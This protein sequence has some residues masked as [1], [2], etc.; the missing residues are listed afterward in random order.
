MPRTAIQLVVDPH[1]DRANHRPDPSAL[2]SSREDASGDEPSAKCTC[3][4]SGMTG[5]MEHGAGA[6]TSPEGSSGDKVAVLSPSFAAPGV[7]PAVHEQAMTRLDEVTGLVP[8]E[9][10]TTRR[11]KAT[12]RGPRRRP[13]RRL[14]R[15]R[16]PGSARDDRRRRPDHRGPAPRRSPVAGRSEAVPRLQRQHE[17]LVLAVDPGCR[18][19]S[20]AA[21]RRFTLVP[22]RRSTPA[23][24]RPFGPP[25]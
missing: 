21:R 12:P 1:Q 23:T 5:R 14:R 20:T 11:V 25:S 16:D 6:C 4:D 17:H 24:A 3:W 13:Q 19:A 7:A 22:A 2:S 18:W 15:P 9:Y 10:P 8:V